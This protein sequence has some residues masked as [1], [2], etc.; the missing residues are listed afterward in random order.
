MTELIPK[1]I[2][3]LISEGYSNIEFD[4]TY[5]NFSG[6]DVYIFYGDTD[7]SVEIEVLI[8]ENTYT[9]SDRYIGEKHYVILCENSLSGLV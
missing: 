4:E 2:E 1:I 5:E 3:L 9:I 8:K 6:D 7:A